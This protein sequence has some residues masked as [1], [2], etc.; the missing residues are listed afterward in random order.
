MLAAVFDCP[1]PASGGSSGLGIKVHHRV[2]QRTAERHGSRKGGNPEEAQG[3]NRA[4][5]YIAQAG[6]NNR[7]RDRNSQ[8]R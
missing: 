5:H 6:I 1:C 2:F 4:V 3:G 8:D 7:E